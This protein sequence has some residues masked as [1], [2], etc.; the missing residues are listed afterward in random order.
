MMGSGLWGWLSYNPAESCTM[1]LMGPLGALLIAVPIV[2]AGL[3]V[4]WAARRYGRVPAPLQ[5][6]AAEAVPTARGEP[7]RV[8]RR[9]C[10][11]G[12][13]LLLVGGAV[14]WLTA[15]LAIYRIPAAGIYAIPVVLAA[16]A[17]AR[18]G[19]YG[20]KQRGDFGARL[21]QALAYILGV[22]LLFLGTLGVG[23][24]VL[25]LVDLVGITSRAPSEVWFLLP[26][27]G[28]LLVLGGIAVLF[29]GGQIWAE[30]S[31][32]ESS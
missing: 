8:R 7:A 9:L 28:A 29:A 15:A 4:A 23:S 5:A 12:V 24:G 31:G 13:L 1:A 10:G 16:W 6:E 3:F 32:P 19:R 26:L 21:G 2:P 20:R 14:P 22:V 17:F 25:D 27:V 11:I 18:A 30:A